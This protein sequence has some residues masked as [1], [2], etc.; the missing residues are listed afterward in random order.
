[1]GI[2]AMRTD[3][4]KAATT[5]LDANRYIYY[6]IVLSFCGKMDKKCS[7]RILNILDYKK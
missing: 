4:R 1:M 6:Y 3:N 2:E 5:E 7:A